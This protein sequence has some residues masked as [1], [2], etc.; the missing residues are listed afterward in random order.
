MQMKDSL[1]TVTKLTADGAVRVQVPTKV[2]G[3]DAY[4][5]WY[6]RPLPLDAPTARYY[7]TKSET[8]L[9]NKGE[10][11]REG[12]LPLTCDIALDR[13]VEVTMRDG[14]VMLTD[15]FRPVDAGSYPAIVSWSPY[16]KVVGGQWVDDLPNRSGVPRDAVSDLMKFE[17]ADPAFW[18]AQGYVVLNPDS[19]GAYASGGNIGFWGRQLAEDGYDFIE[20]AAGQDWSNGK[21]GMAGNSWLAAS[22]WFIAAE[23]PPHLAAIAPWEGLSDVMRD[24]SIRGGIPMLTFQ[25]LIIKS[26]AGENLVEDMPRMTVAEQCDTVYWQDKAAEL[27][28]VTVPAYVVAS[29]DNM[30]HTHGTFDAFRRLSSTDKWLRVHNTMEWP[31]FYRPENTAELLSFF[32]H[33][34]RD[35]ANGWKDTPRVRISVIDP[36]GTDDVNRVVDEWPP[37]GYPHQKLFLTAD[38]TLVTT[39][40]QHQQ[41]IRYPV[42]GGAAI[43]RTTFDHEAEVVGYLKLRLWV[44][45]EGTD[46]LDLLALVS[47]LDAQ[48]NPT[49]HDLGTGEVSPFFASGLQRASRRA[50]DP[51][52]STDSEPFLSM[53]AERRLSAGEIV[54]LD[55]AIWP[56]G[57]RLHAGE[58]L[59][60]MVLPFQM[61]PLDMAFGSARI[62]LPV[63]SFTFVPDESVELQTQGGGP[64]TVP[65]WVAEQTVSDAPRNVGTHVLHMG[66]E[67]DSHLLVP[68]KHL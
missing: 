49:T 6:R 26:F 35:H 34:L 25:E 10:I 8:L 44:Q 15:V 17:G 38:S 22:Q 48:G 31:D 7:G 46:D 2:Y 47:K 42:E 20:W 12:A 18:V 50:L 64:E 57:L 32:D 3:D 30:A 58:T 27:E 36:G 24:S 37:T 21:I 23:Q 13:D 29:Y 63:D 14:T 19:R 67:Y 33:Y 28:R 4:P 43:F 41:T 65:S 66:G 56:T 61:P 60:L 40:A 52:R 9:L 1:M 55:I 59:Q 62:S 53:A 45:A 51:I 54:P 16:G 68:L 5:V 39:T 11:R